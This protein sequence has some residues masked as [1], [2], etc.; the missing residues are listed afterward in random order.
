MRRRNL[1]V[2]A[3]LAVFLSQGAALAAERVVLKIEGL[4][5]FG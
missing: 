3:A 4:T 1:L 2:G 5:R